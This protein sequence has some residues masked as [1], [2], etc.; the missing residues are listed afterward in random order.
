MS[1]LDLYLTKH[2]LNT[3]QFAKACNITVDALNELLQARLIPAPSY[4][5]TAHSTLKSYVFGEMAAPEA[6]PAHYFH[7]DNTVWTTIAQQQIKIHG[8]HAAFEALK[9]LF[10]M[11]FQAALKECNYKIWP[12]KDSFNADGSPIPQGLEARSQ[13]IWEHFLYGTL[14]LCVAHP[15]S[16]A[17]IAEKEV[18]QEKLN[19]LS[20]TPFTAAE[21]PSLLAL[22]DAFAQASMPFSPIE[23]S[24]SSR[25][26]LVDDF[27]LRIKAQFRLPTKIA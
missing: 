25:K 20:N 11:R 10:M 16:E 19:A 1:E 17:A 13:A 24:L 9:A 2:Y 23:Y 3:E 27:R 18:L 6:T 21:I 8:I 7:P 14:G 5:V 26:R 12:L 22:I 15:V 4:I